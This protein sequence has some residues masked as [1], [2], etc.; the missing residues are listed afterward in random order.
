MHSKQI[1]WITKLNV[2]LKVQNTIPNTLI[3]QIL[4]HWVF[5]YLPVFLTE[6]FF[7]PH[8]TN[9]YINAPCVNTPSLVHLVFCISKLSINDFK[10][11]IWGLLCFSTNLPVYSKSIITR[12]QHSDLKYHP[13]WFMYVKCIWLMFILISNNFQFLLLS[14][15]LLS[16][17]LCQWKISSYR[18]LCHT[19]NFTCN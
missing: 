13:T 3:M 16:T 5:N 14:T 15:Q 10:R 17:N 18:I 1:F 2:K 9:A 11:Y 8:I 7:F 6:C 19:A 4:I 12:L